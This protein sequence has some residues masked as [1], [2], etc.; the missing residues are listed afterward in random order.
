MNADADTDAPPEVKAEAV[1]VD[2]IVR[3]ERVRAIFDARRECREARTE[4]KDHKRA[5]YVADARAIYRD[6]L[7]AYVREVESLC[8]QTPE[9]RQLWNQR[10]FGEIDITPTVEDAPGDTDLVRLQ[11][12]TFVHSAPD[13]RMRQVEG[14]S[15]LFEL[16]PPIP[17]RFEVQVA[18][19]RDRTVVKT[20]QIDRDIPIAVLDQMFG[21]VNGY[22]A[23]IGFDIDVETAETTATADYSDIV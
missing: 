1:D 3:Q 19:G 4:A 11:D 10:N 15:A 22:L 20:L 13:G 16:S 18:Q 21:A 14:L 23:E 9:G 6:R 5:G 2:E 17:A 7:E 12:G 8:S